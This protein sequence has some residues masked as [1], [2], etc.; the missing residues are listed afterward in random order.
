[1]LDKFLILSL[2]VEFGLV[3]Y[4]VAMACTK[5]DQC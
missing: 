2:A 1:M 3:C 4:L 5:D